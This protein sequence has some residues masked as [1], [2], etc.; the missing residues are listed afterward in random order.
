MQNKKAIT[1]QMFIYIFG[2]IVISLILA[3]GLKAFKDIN[4]AAKNSAI[5]DFEIKFKNDIEKNSINQGSVTDLSYS[6]QTNAERICIFDL[7]NEKNRDSIILNFYPL[8]RDSLNNNAENVFLI[9]KNEV[10]GFKSE[11]VRFDKYPYYYCSD[12]KKGS[13]NI[14]VKGTIINEESVSL[15]LTD[16]IAKKS[17]NQNVEQDQYLFSSDGLLFMKINKDTIITNPS[18]SY[19]FDISIEVEKAGDASEIYRF[20]PSG[21]QF[22]KDIEIGFKVQNCIIPN[23]Y[24]FELGNRN[25]T[26]QECKDN[27]VIFKVDMI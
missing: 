27:F 25:I 22:N 13:F 4:A 19:P 1:N 10:T 17:F 21:T 11:Y 2:I 9:N 24:T 7:Y 8:I 20:E 18:N 26:G 12:I 14:K 3:F 23:S 6:I 15:I 16:N 5:K